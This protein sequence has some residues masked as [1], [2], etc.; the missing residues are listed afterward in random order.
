MQ[1]VGENP[2]VDQVIYI[3]ADGVSDLVVLE[4]CWL[5][6]SVLGHL[7]SPEFVAKSRVTG[8]YSPTDF[9]MSEPTWDAVE[10]LPVLEALGVC[11]QCVSDTD[12]E[13][14]FP[15]YNALSADPRS[16]WPDDEE[17]G[18]AGDVVHGGVLIKSVYTRLLGPIFTRFQVRIQ[19]IQ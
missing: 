18:F 14:E 11:T 10:I 16:L 1:Y 15:C 2:Y 6:K 4:P 5:T 17:S 9:Q 19:H 13:Y 7:L 8:V 12:V 3:K